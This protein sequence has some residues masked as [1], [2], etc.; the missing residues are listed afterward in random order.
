MCSSCQLCKRCCECRKAPKYLS[1]KALNILPLT[2]PGGVALISRLP[3]TLGVELE[4]G[5]WKNLINLSRAGI[6]GIRF[7]H[8]RDW[9]VKPSEME[10]VVAPLR[11]DAFVR[12]MLELSRRAT[13]EMVV[14]NDS[15]ALHVHVG[16]KDLSYWEV[17]RLL[18]VYEQLEPEISLNLLTYVYRQA[19]EEPGRCD[20]LF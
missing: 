3:R 11:G 5:D 4:I 1:D 14:L 12:G 19:T 13:Q 9:S 16:A 6:P 10:M 18:T 17:R 2:R 7:T 8:T 15:C 20:D